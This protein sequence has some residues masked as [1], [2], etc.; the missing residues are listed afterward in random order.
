MHKTSEVIT[1]EARFVPEKAQREGRNIVGRK[2]H[3]RNCRDAEAPRSIYEIKS[4]SIPG[5]INAR[6]ST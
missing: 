3:I 5:E 6:T 1:P 4:D 2:S